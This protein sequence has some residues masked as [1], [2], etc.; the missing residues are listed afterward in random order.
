MGF[1]SGSGLCNSNQPEFNERRLN[2]SGAALDAA[3]EKIDGFLR[4][5]E[6]YVPIDELVRLRDTWIAQGAI[7]AEEA[8]KLPGIKEAAEQAFAKVL[9][10]DAVHHAGFNTEEYAKMREKWIAAGI[11]TAEEA[12]SLPRIREIAEDDL[13]DAA[14]AVN[15][16]PDTIQALKTHWVEVGVITQAEADKLIAEGKRERER[17]LRSPGG[18]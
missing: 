17:Y 7:T 16:L 9:H 8:N 3:S 15:S 13:F 2:Q 5:H 10:Q 6:K 1:E 4:S 14:S 12:N 11:V 18:A